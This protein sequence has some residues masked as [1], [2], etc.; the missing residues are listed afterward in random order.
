MAQ[1]RTYLEAQRYDEALV[2][3][4]EMEEMAKEDK[5]N[6]IGSFAIIL[7]LYLTKQH[8]EQRSTRSWDVFVRNAVREIERTNKRRN[9]GR[10]YA[11][12]A[13]V[14]EIL[15]TVFPVALDRASLEIHEG[16][17]D[18]SEIATMIHPEAII[19]QAI[20]LILQ[21]RSAN[22]ITTS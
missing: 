1:L 19:S 13:D 9:S 22:Q 15:T 5:I 17:Y 18:S 4:G 11:S 10:Y 2:L 12:E 7:L 8:V 21:N 16:R 3:I 20:A 14:R 6:K